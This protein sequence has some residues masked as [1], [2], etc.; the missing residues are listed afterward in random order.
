MATLKDQYKNQKDRIR[1]AI[2]DIEKTGASFDKSFED[3]IGKRPKR[4]TKASVNKLAKITKDELWRMAKKDDRSA[5][6]ERMKRREEASRKGG[7]AAQA[8]RKK[9]VK[10]IKPAQ[11]EPIGARPEPIPAGD[12]GFD[13]G[14]MFYD[15]MKRLLQEN[16]AD[17]P[18]LSE[19][20]DKLDQLKEKLTPE[21]FS[22][23]ADDEGDKFAEAVQQEIRYK[24]SPTD[25]SKQASR[26]SYKLQQAH[27][28]AL[29][30]LNTALLKYGITSEKS[31]D[32]FTDDS[33]ETWIDLSSVEN[34]EDWF[35]D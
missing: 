9:P 19:L 16:M 34:D 3:I 22:K 6:K 27:K 21:Q 24:P 10:P 25:N 14:T 15:N 33:G 12:E 5:W 20:L 4:I 29:T 8:K 32:T 28:D 31:Y 13:D 17:V 26:K 1:K 2:K 7:K 11:T 35:F 30:I 18:D 23:F